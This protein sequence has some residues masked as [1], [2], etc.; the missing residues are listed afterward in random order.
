M[1]LKLKN[2]GRGSREYVRSQGFLRNMLRQDSTWSSWP[3]KVQGLSV[4]HT[5]CL[6]KFGRFTFGLLSAP[7][8][9]QRAMTE[10]FK[11]IEKCEVIVIVIW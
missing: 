8:D 1:F 11:G 3:R 6:V 4:L 7:D 2:G 5:F 10:M 9:F